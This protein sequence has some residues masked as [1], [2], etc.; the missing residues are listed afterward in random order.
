[1]VRTVAQLSVVQ[2]LP[3]LVNHRAQDIAGTPCSDSEGANGSG[4]FCLQLPSGA[5]AQY[6]LDATGTK[7]WIRT[8]IKKIRLPPSLPE[9]GLAG[10][11]LA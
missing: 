1:V 11:V 8:R 5:E 10:D 9:Q 7:F 6:K 3:G 4:I 2:T